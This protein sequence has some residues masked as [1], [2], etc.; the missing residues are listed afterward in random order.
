MTTPGGVA[1]NVADIDEKAIRREV[2]EE[3]VMALAHAKATAVRARLAASP[4]R[5]PALPALLITSDQVVVHNGR[6]LEKPAD[7]AEA[8]AFLRGYGSAPARTCGAICV[9]NLA[10][11]A[12]A[13]ALDAA[14]VHFMPLPADVIEAL[15]AE[16]SVFAC[17]GGL[18]VEHPRVAPFVT[19]LEGGMDSVL[20]LS[21]ALTLTLLLRAAG[22]GED[23]ARR[24]AEAAAAAWAAAAEGEQAAA[25][26]PRSA[27]G[28]RSRCRCCCATL[29]CQTR[30]RQRAPGRQR[31]ILR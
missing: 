24:A 3:L 13:A 21:K 28:G 7:A 19:R 23:A 17:A 26:T 15:I 25:W 31:R 27:G 14:A 6:I 29:L 16:G 10:T 8:R 30:S 18:M 20:G 9:T 22:E 2:P 1:S 4:P 5:L 12:V 11:G